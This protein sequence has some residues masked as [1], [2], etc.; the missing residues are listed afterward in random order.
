ML[1]A[2]ALL[3][4]IN[5]NA[6]DSLP[7][8][9]FINPL[10]IPVTLAGTFGEIRSDHYHTGIDMRTEGRE[11]LVVHAVASGYV[12]RIVVSP[13]GYGNALYITHPN[14]YISLYG[15][16]SKFNRKITNYV[17]SK[18]YADEKYTQ[19]IAL[20]AG[21]FNVEQ[22]DTIA[23][24]GSS[25]GADGPHLHF[26]I[27]NA[28]NDDPINPLLAGYKVVDNLAPKIKGIALYPL[29]DSSTINNKHEALYIKAE[30]V[31]NRY[32]LAADSNINAYGSIG[33]A[34]SCFDMADS[35]ENRNGPYIKV[36]KD[37]GD[38][39]YYTRMNVLDFSTIHFIN[40]HIDYAAMH[41]RIDTL[42]YSFLQDN[43][44]LRIYKKLVNKGRIYCRT[45]KNHT[46][47]YFISDFNGNTSTLAFTIQGDIKKAKVY[48]DTAKFLAVASWDKPFSYSSG[49]MKIQI[50]A[51]ALFNNMH[52]RY[53]LD[54]TSSNTAISP[55]Y[56]IQDANTPLSANYTLMLKPNPY[57]PD[58]LLKKAVIVRLEGKSKVSVGGKWDNGYL[59]THPRIFGKFMIA[60]DLYRPV[61][62]PVNVFKDKDMSKDTVMAF[63]VTDNL[64]GVGYFK[65]TIDGKWIL[66][67]SDSKKNWIYYTFDDHVAKGPHH[68]RLVVSDEVGNTT[69]YETDFTR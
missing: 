7:K 51:G 28:R 62:K 32:L 40:G 64:S 23:F 2:I 19:D 41:N 20:A 3:L 21:Q 6:Q 47:E 24:S 38:T 54:T 14:G 49:G 53:S 9:Y 50:P 10:D 66:M 57:L 63:D 1:F 33:I 16:L 56:H 25:G 55:V 52:F 12:S 29:N 44:K 45:K 68:L 59:V 43:D 8:N 5:S 26:E 30:K 13:Y 48:K 18:Q 42:E 27:R 11:G 17:K 37:N 35:I 22:G 39:I 4:A 58:S 65:G 15:H 67:E 46:M 31:N 61:I 60:I 36:L 34:I 69:V